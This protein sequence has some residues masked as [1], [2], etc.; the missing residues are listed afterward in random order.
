MHSGT[1][2]K[3]LAGRP[4][5]AMSSRDGV[6]QLLSRI[7]RPF[8]QR[9]AQAEARPTAQVSEQSRGGLHSSTRDR[10]A[11]SLPAWLQALV[12][13]LRAQYLLRHIR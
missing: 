6:Q 8:R 11:H 12:Q 10:P 4:R 2:A 1:L 13:G 9:P 3:V 7:A 5:V